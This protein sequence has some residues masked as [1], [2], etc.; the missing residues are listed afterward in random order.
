MSKTKIVT[1]RVWSKGLIGDPVSLAFTFSPDLEL[2]KAVRVLDATAAIKDREAILCVAD[3]S[4]RVL[5]KDGDMERVELDFSFDLKENLAESVAEFFRMKRENL[6]AYHEKVP[7]D[8]DPES[9]IFING[10][11]E[12]TGKPEIK[13]SENI[14]NYNIAVLMACSFS[15]QVMDAHGLLGDIEQINESADS[16]DDDYSSTL[17][18]AFSFGMGRML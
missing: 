2:L 16:E 18:P 8:A 17:I 6:L 15:K 1:F 9:S 10:F 5:N 4:P 11:N 12:S 13:L 14:N 7:S 3:Y